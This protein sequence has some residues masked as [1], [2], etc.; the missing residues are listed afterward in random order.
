MMSALS[1]Y[2]ACAT[3]ISRLYGEP[4]LASGVLGS[5]P[6][7]LDESTPMAELVTGAD[8]EELVRSTSNERAWVQLSWNS[9]Y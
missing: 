7:D 9:M 8:Y 6:G 2:L 5:K 1:S 4:M 3:T